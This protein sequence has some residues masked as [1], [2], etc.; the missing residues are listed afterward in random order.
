MNI[1]D[2][3]KFLD[4]LWDWTP[5][6]DCF[7]PTKIRVTDIDGFVERHGKFLVIE[8]KLPD[9]DVPTGQ[10]IMF[11]AMRATGLFTVFIVWGETNAPTMIQQWGLTAPYAADLE[12]LRRIVRAWFKRVNNEQDNNT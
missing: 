5:L 11:D 7:A 3:E 2:P 12:E 9:N 6:N 1:R 8:A 10:A 4:T